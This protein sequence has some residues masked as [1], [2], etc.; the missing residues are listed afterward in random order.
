MSA[1]VVFLFDGCW[2]ASMYG[3]FLGGAL[4]LPVPVVFPAV[5]RPV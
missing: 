2:C 1:H 4:C 3:L 5:L